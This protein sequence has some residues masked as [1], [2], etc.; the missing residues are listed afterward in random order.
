MIQLV[1]TNG[2]GIIIDSAKVESQEEIL[3]I[4]TKWHEEYQFLNGDSV[5]F[6]DI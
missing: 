2:D 5:S 4:L 3:N 6:Y 1:L